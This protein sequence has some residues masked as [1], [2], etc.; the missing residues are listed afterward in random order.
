MSKGSRARP[1]DKKRF[2]DGWDRIFGGGK[3]MNERFEKFQPNIPIVQDSYG[4]DFQWVNGKKQFLFPPHAD[5]VKNLR[6]QG[7]PDEDIRE[8]LDMT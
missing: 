6:S 3:V 7:M 4:R 8:W 2:N 1:V 5:E